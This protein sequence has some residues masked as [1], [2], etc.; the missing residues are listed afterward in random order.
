MVNIMDIILKMNT[1][2]IRDTCTYSI[3]DSLLIIVYTRVMDGI[4]CKS[5]SI[6]E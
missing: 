5:Q 2:N 6:P 4:G 3:Q 1:K